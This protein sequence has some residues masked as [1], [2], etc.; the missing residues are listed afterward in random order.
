MEMIQNSEDHK[1]NP[2]LVN[3]MTDFIKTY[4]S[5]KRTKKKA[6]REETVDSL[7]KHKTTKKRQKKLVSKNQEEM[8]MKKKSEMCP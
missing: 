7:K 8:N 3:D 4:D 1:R 2:Y 6:V 5:T